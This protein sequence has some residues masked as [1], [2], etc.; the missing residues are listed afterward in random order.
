M[1]SLFL[2]RGLFV[3]G[4]FV[5]SV[6]SRNEASVAFTI[7]T[8]RES[9]LSG[10]MTRFALAAARLPLDWT[11]AAF[12]ASVVTLESDAHLAVI[13]VSHLTIDGWSA[14][15]IRREI[16][17]AYNG[18][19]EG[20]RLG[21]LR[22]VAGHAIDFAR[23]EQ[24]GLRLRRLDHAAAY[25][26]R[27]W[28]TIG[29]ALLDRAQLP[30]ATRATGVEP[31]INT[32]SLR[33]DDSD[34]ARVNAACARL[35]VTPYIFVRAVFA[36]LLH[37]YTGRARIA[38]WSNFA[39]RAT[40]GADSWV[41]NCATHHLVATTVEGETV[42]GYCRHHQA[43]LREAQRHERLALPA[44][45]LFSGRRYHPGNVRVVFD[46]WPDPMERSAPGASEFP[47]PEGRAWID[48]DLRLRASRQSLALQATFN[49]ARHSP[50][51]AEA[52]LRDLHSLI[53]E[54]EE[55]LDQP[56]ASLVKRAAH[57]AA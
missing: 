49:Q 41:A 17:D 24:D 14:G 13:V 25:W 8:D 12:R 11:T 43:D 44:L 31:V 45:P 9:S 15:I 21:A 46:T 10:R 55:S 50:E 38:I 2:R 19:L 5:Q 34:A 56:M 22:P 1:L 23:F 3:P 52:L 30:C 40:A 27:Q 42:A 29:P 26:N 37:G 7:D 47:V 51:G 32:R 36:L 16:I 48:L 57:R 4:F 53:L 33:L 6:K 35:Q 54:A 18:V 39:N 28:S 20:R